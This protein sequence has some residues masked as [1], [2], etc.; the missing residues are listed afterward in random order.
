MCALHTLVPTSLRIELSGNPTEVLHSGGYG[1]V[2]KRDYQGQ[3]VAVK[4][5]RIRS[6]HD[7]QKIIRVRYW[8]CFLI[9]VIADISHELCRDFARSLCRGRLFGIQM[10]YRLWE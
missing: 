10:Y 2:S 3:E 8:W 6:P 5:L 7:L 4:K 9:H 1:D